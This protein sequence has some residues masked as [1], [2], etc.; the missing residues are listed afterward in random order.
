MSLSLNW[1]WTPHPPNYARVVTASGV[2]RHIARV[3]VL[4]GTY[5]TNER[6]VPG[7]TQELGSDLH[8]S[9]L[10]SGACRPASP[11]P[12]VAHLH[13]GWHDALTRLYIMRMCAACDVLGHFCADDTLRTALLYV[14]GERAALGE[15]VMQLTRATWD[16]AQNPSVPWVMVSA[17]DNLF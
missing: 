8:E 6:A 3:V 9:A 1:L 17:P 15:A 11:V 14:P 13:A 2:M 16:E 5:V 12:S 10:S 7:A 4:G